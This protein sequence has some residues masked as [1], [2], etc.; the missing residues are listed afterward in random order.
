M[1]ESNEEWGD[2]KVREKDLFKEQARV[3]L[4]KLELKHWMGMVGLPAT[5]S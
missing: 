3:V 2:K 4:R 1:K 5:T